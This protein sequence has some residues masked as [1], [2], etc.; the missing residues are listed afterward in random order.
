MTSRPVPVLYIAGTGRSG[1]T[2]LASVLG[3][4]D[5][6]FSAGE[7]RFTWE[8]GLSDGA[9]CGCHRPVVEC[10]VWSTT[11]NDGFGGFDGPDVDAILHALAGQTRIRNLPAILRR[12]G[13]VDGVSDELKAALPALYRSIL[14]TTGSRVIVDSS[15]LPTYA[16]LLSD[17]DDV[18]V[19]I[20]HLV[21]DPRAAAWSW[22]RR[23]ATG[24]VEGFDEEMDRFSPSKSASLWS[25][26]NGMM[27]QMWRSNRE[28]YL[29]VRYEDFAAE[30]EGVVE[31][32]L[33]FAGIDDA[34]MPFSGPGTVDLP[35][36]HAIAG[37]PN[38]MRHGE[39]SIRTDN[40]WE[41]AMPKRDRVA[42]TTLTAPLL[43]RFGYRIQP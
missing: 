17:L 18:D 38:R 40:E 22:M 41:H 25:L 43:P 35:P 8:R 37:N 15:K 6:M 27:S 32:I 14:T 29:P 30:P 1:S 31:R 9:M 5:G 26:W 4:V 12:R 7:L 24:A 34:E 10:D 13:T 21:R 23:G 16:M 2:L 3:S 42:V 39:T 20:V 36:N 11:F 33:E 19:R 28:R